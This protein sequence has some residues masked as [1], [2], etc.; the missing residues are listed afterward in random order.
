MKKMSGL[1]VKRVMLFI[2][3]FLTAGLLGQEVFAQPPKTQEVI[4]WKLQSVFPPPEKVLGYWGVYGQ[5]AEVVRKVK[6]RTNGKFDIKLYIPGTIG[7]GAGE[8][9][10]AVKK[11]AVEMSVGGGIYATGLIPEARI[12]HGGLPYG[13]KK[14]EQGASLILKTDFVKVMRQAYLERTNSYLLGLTSSSSATYIT[15]SPINR[16]EDL[17][18]KKIRV[19]GGLTMT[20]SAQGATPV[21]IAPGELYMALQRGTIDGTLFPPYTGVSYNLFEVSKYVSLP[22]GYPYTAMDWVV[23][24]EAWNKLPKEFQKALQEEVD[25][26]SRFTY[27]ESG[28]NLEK[29]T[30]EEGVKKFGAKFVELS[31]EEFSKFR[32]AVMPLW[33]EMAGISGLSAK[34][35]QV[36]KADIDAK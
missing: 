25:E 34:L 16:L 20:V 28:P 32:N 8:A 13:A 10:N 5:A 17:K 21:N 15:N 36:I 14:A 23:N 22:C 33:N 12:Q 26:M 6:E 18:G 1:N 24:M 11:G 2:F 7:I 29:V 30:Q 4:S 19:S 31:E 3:A 27:I 35:V 9:L